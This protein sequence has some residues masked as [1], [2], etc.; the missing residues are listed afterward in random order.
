MDQTIYVKIS[1][2]KFEYKQSGWF[3]QT[4]KWVLLYEVEW[5]SI[6]FKVQ[7]T[8][9]NKCVTQIVWSKHKKDCLD[10]NEHKYNSFNKIFKEWLSIHL[11]DKMKIQKNYKMI[12]CILDTVE[13]RRMAFFPRFASKDCDSKWR[14]KMAIQDGVGIIFCG[15]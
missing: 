6:E 15:L 3:K 5:N 7:Q 11:D 14:F 8:L 4:S 1:K 2:G 9:E 13:Y 12:Q 10:S